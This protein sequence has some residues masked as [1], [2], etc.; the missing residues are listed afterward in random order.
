MGQRVMAKQRGNKRE[1]EREIEEREGREGLDYSLI[2]QGDLK[3][4]LV[5]KCTEESGRT[6][7]SDL[8]YTHEPSSVLTHSVFRT[9]L[10]EA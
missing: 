4:R 2:Q 8:A 5:R 3:R 1:R 6:L 7:S 9:V 10:G